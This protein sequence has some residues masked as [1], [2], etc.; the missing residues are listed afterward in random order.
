MREPPVR[1]LRPSRNICSSFLAW[2][3]VHHF[4]LGHL[5]QLLFAGRWLWLAGYE[6][7]SAGVEHEEPVAA[8][9][10]FLNGVLIEILIGCPLV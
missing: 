2:V 1:T 4:L 10:Q 3:V 5:R 9:V 6:V 7:P 8:A